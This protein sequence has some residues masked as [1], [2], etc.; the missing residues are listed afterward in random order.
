MFNLFIKKCFYDAIELKKKFSIT[1]SKNWSP[2]TIMNEIIVQLGHYSFT[3]CG[4]E[5]VEEKERCIN[6]PKD[7]LCDIL[8][9]FCALCGKLNI[10]IEKI[11]EYN[12][13]TNSKVEVT[14]QLVSLVGQITEVIMEIEGY[15]HS[16]ERIGYVNNLDFII[17]KINK[18]FS[19]IFWIAENQNYDMV[20][21]FNIMKK[22]ALNFL[23]KYKEEVNV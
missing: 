9:Q 16:K 23:N 1:E 2:L 13:N 21:E 19:I 5:F 14:L 22:D 20:L 12:V 4:N 17:E 8:L 15:R 6:N 10:S 18:C 11:K 3:I 7:E